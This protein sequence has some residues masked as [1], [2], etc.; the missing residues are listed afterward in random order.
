MSSLSLS[1]YFYRT[2]FT[3]STEPT[4]RVCPKDAV[5]LDS[6]PDTNSN[7]DRLIPTC[8]P[9]HK[10]GRRCVYDEQVKTPLSRHHFKEV[11]S[12]LARTKARCCSRLFLNHVEH[13]Q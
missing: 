4:V 7:C 10:R 2:F 5:S 6:S 3:D 11:E 9:C 12:E 13:T 8:A 1:S